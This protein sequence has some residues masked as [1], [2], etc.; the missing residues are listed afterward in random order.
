MIRIQRAS[1]GFGV[2]LRNSRLSFDATGQSDLASIAEQMGAVH[3][4][5]LT[6]DVT[7]LIVG[8]YDTPKY[9]FVAKERSDVKVMQA[10]WIAAV[11]ASWL[12]G[13]V[14]DVEAAELNHKLPTYH[15]LRICVTGF[16]DLAFRKQ[17]EDEIISAGGEYSGNLTKDITHLIAKKP[18]SEKYEYAKHREIKTVSIEWHIQSLERGMIL[19]EGLYHPLL[20]VS[21]RGRGAWIRRETSTTSLGKRTREGDGVSQ[22]ARKLRR[23]TSARFETHNDSLWT[24]IVSAEVKQE[25]AAA[26]EWDNVARPAG[27]EQ[28]TELGSRPRDIRV[29]TLK[30]DHGPQVLKRSQSMGNLENLLGKPLQ[31]GGLFRDMTILPQGFD[32]KKATILVRH[33]LSHGASLISSPSEFP[34]S[35]AYLLIPHTTHKVDTRSI[36]QNGHN[37]QVVTDLWIERCLHRKRVVEPSENVMNTPLEHFP[38]AGFEKLKISST[39]FQGVDLLHASK[40]VG[41]LGGIYDEF[42]TDKSTV[43]VCNQVVPGHE[44]LRH[45]CLWGIPAVKAE[46]LWDCVRRGQRLP[47]DDYLLQAPSHSNRDPGI[48]SKPE[49]VVDHRSDS[50]LQLTGDIA[51][52]SFKRPMPSKS[53]HMHPQQ[54]Q[55]M[56]KSVP[57]LG[58]SVLD[59]PFPDN[60]G[61]L[62]L[63]DEAEPPPPPDSSPGDRLS[64]DSS[65]AQRPPLQEITPNSSPPKPQAPKTTASNSL[66]SPLEPAAPV[67]RADDNSGDHSDDNNDNDTLGPAISS[68]LSHH[69][70]ARS[71]NANNTAPGHPT[72]TSSHPSEQQHQQQPLTRRR[73]RQLLG[74]AP[75]NLSS[76]SHSINKPSRASSVDTLNTDGLGTPLE[77]S[78]THPQSNS[79]SLS[80]N[81]TTTKPT[82][83]EEDSS[84]KPR[85]IYDHP[86]EH[87]HDPDRP[88][89]QGEHLQMTQL[90]YADP[91]V[92]AWRE[93]VAIKMAGGTVKE[94]SRGGSGV[95]PVVKG[96]KGAAPNAGGGG[97]EK[98]LGI[99]KRTRLA[100]AG[101]RG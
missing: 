46:W 77:A 67:Q 87:E 91:N 24:D 36:F 23:T 92:A 55:T 83:A 26:S 42:F 1:E 15:G 60:A 68:L 84:N 27:D 7:H 59:N 30:A 90:G 61:P 34:Q 88:P 58:K 25:R 50:R 86:D 8:D 6:S 45:A 78:A 74:R 22:N 28:V 101:G 10:S 69:Q 32:E 39:G 2:H 43:L 97:G 94:R 63:P 18:G 57:N 82:P 70:A 64:A 12:E 80:R 11:R 16:D 17:L 72:S 100:G 99:A 73:R 41:L 89:S 79:H 71:S 93:R 49:K 21:E 33:L 3:K 75:S 53:H 62:L 14:T 95:A 37:P 35:N 98:S 4:F 54:G 44:K 38:I 51:E 9:K 47:F 85:A 19:D 76:H 13:G 52:K 96:K 5:D 56:R 48:I 40:A 66:P 65:Q 31:Q 81:S 29:G 20:P